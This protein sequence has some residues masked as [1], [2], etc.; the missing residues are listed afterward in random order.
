MSQ[1]KFDNLIL[2]KREGKAK[3]ILNRPQAL[4]ALNLELLSELKE[5]FEEVERDKDIGVII[6]KREGRAFCAGMDLK[7]MEN[8]LKR[9]REEDLVSFVIPI[10]EILGMMESLSKPIICAVHG[11]AI[12]GGF[13]L[14]YFSDMVIASEDAVFQDTHG[15]WGLVPAAMESIKLPRVVG[16]FR[17]K[18][19]SSTSDV[20]TAKEAEQMGLVYKVV[21]RE[22]LDEEVEQLA[23]KILKQSKLSLAITK[24]QINKCVKVNWSTALEIDD[25]IRKGLISNSIPPEGESRL[26]AFIERRAS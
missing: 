8:L 10:K 6:L 15:R 26:R 1:K 7:V 21:P 22:R 16:T 3:I 19:I 12:T 14:V 9:G 25:L 17:A 5:A 18:R 4:N 24:S 13:A 23:T 2:E 11:Y 20:I